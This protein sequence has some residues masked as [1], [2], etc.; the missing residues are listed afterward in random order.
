MA[1][2]PNRCASRPA[3]AA[4]AA[5]VACL[6]AC[7]S[8]DAEKHKPAALVPIEAPLA[9]HSTWT[10][11]LGRTDGYF[12]RPCAVE[13]AVYAADS[14][15][16]LVRIDPATGREVWQ[17]S[18]DGGISGGVGCDGTTVAVGGPRGHVAVFNAEGKPVWEAQSTSD[19]L[20]APLVG[21]DLVLVHSSDHHITAYDAASGKRRWTFVKQGP[22][23][24][25]RAES[26]MRFSGDNVL[27]GFPGGRLVSIALSN[28]ASRWE[29]IVSDPKGATEVERLADVM[30]LPALDEGDVCTASYQG[31]IGCFN[32]AT[33]DLRWV[34][35]FPASAAVAATA[36]LVIGVDAESHVK[37]FKRSSGALVW[38]NGTLAFRALAAPVVVGNWV[39]LGD[40]EGIVHFLSLADGKSVGRFDAGR[41]LASTPLLWNGEA[42][43][44]THAGRL[45]LLSATAG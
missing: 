14:S 20:S 16:D 18:V 7:A 15:G 23:L 45:V 5:L 10:Y 12:L 2:I 3:R 11:E 28:G 29:A 21:H 8:S 13:Q 36:E 34:R 33:G 38:Q 4:L 35:E 17:A 42:L 43:F 30:G 39:A 25:L 37:A 22:S 32:A 26:G 6:A 9:V 31:R 40:A 27:A 1:S 24:S 19:I 44:Q 41:A